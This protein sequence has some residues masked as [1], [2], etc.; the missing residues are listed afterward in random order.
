MAD[1]FDINQFL[2]EEKETETKIDKELPAKVEANDDFDIDQFL[3]E[4]QKEEAREIAG[5]PRSGLSDLP[6]RTETGPSQ[7]EAALHGGL[8]GAT[9]GWSDEILGQIAGTAAAPFKEETRTELVK[10]YQDALRERQSAAQ[11]EHPWTYGG[12]ELVGAIATPIPGLGVARGVLKGGQLLGKAAKA[13]DK[14]TALRKMARGAGQGGT[15][16]GIY[17]LGVAEE[18]TPDEFL[19]GAALGATLGGVLS[20]TKPL[21]DSL[22]KTIGTT[23]VAQGIAIGAR[24]GYERGKDIVNYRAAKELTDK[25]VKT[26]EKV[27]KQIFD[28]LDL[29]FGKKIK[30]A[31][32]QPNP[33]INI[34]EIYEQAISDIRDAVGP[35]GQFTARQ[36]EKFI[37]EI[38]DQF[39]QKLP[40][41]IKG[42]VQQ[43]TKVKIDPATGQPVSTTITKGG[44]ELAKEIAEVSE[45]KAKKIT[46][47]Y[48]KDLKLK[49]QIQTDTRKFDAVLKGE[50]P[51]KIAPA[52]AL[53]MIRYFDKQVKGLNNAGKFDQASIYKNM[54]DQLKNQVRS[55]L[56][57][58][59]LAK[60]DLE[61]HNLKKLQDH[62]VL[63]KKKY[64]PKLLKIIEEFEQP[65]KPGQAA[66]EKILKT[67]TDAGLGKKQARELRQFIRQSSKEYQVAKFA[68]GGAEQSLYGLQF[69]A[70]P[71]KA[72]RVGAKV[73]K[74]KRYVKKAGKEIDEDLL[75]IPSRSAKVLKYATKA[76]SN[77]L[78][79]IANTLNNSKAPGAKGA[80]NLIN[81]LANT[82][83]KS[84]RN[85]II[86][87]LNQNPTYR[88]VIAEN[89][90]IDEKDAPDAEGTEE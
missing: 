3:A 80:A 31:E 57:S 54:T 86:F 64:N 70:I 79:T 51:N 74:L 38:D 23:K 85:A 12:G 56:D 25:V 65:F 35:G 77:A 50:M 49:D 22:A 29:N 63:E 13:V 33:I 16:G 89:Y 2:D 9:F 6:V 41:K 45:Q 71:E 88:R 10:R 26:E 82:K 11:E 30:A 46:E 55:K 72:I 66:E 36:A 84:L 43:I 52:E 90:D 67:L 81:K 83:D 62:L 59:D 27:R 53:K 68:S 1:D 20:G 18:K 44:K 47:R 17:S 78:A 28:K 61:S 42:A 75:N 5:I 4:E 8:Q 73:G 34:K 48:S 14:S 40:E 24:R 69:G 39:Y 58:E 60:L 87:Q 21:F 76:G 32:A 19:E 7:A 15:I 37:K